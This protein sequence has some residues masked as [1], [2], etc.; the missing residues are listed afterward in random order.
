VT[1]QTCNGDTHALDLRW[2]GGNNDSITIDHCWLHREAEIIWI[3]PSTSNLLIQHSQ[4]DTSATTA[5]E[6]ADIMYTSAVTVTNFTFRYNRI[7]SSDNDGM[8]YETGSTIN[9]LYF[10]GNLYY[11]NMGQIISFKTGMNI[12]NVY[13]YNN[14]FQWDSAATFPSG[15]PWQSFFNWVSTPSS[16]ACENN[17]FESMSGGCSGGLTIDYNAYSTDQ[18]K[19]DS[20]THSFTYT[21][22]TQFAND[23]STSNPSAA[24]FHLTSAGMTS[25]GA[26]GISLS[27]PY[28]TDMDGNTCSA[29]CSV[30]AYHA[31]SSA[32]GPTPPSGLAA[33]VH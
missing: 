4:I 30:G 9:G 2:S 5:S 33:S 23:P 12:S 28:N 6:H 20:G 10:Y 24:D 11:H 19:G 22:G 27:A 31:T 7:F 15:N 17:I 13:I 8:L 3:G 16:G 26:K 21:K 25:F 29:S 18:G 14:V 1:A 32:T